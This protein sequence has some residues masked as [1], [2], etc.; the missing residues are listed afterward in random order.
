MAFGA[1]DFEIVVTVGDR[2][3]NAHFRVQLFPQLI[4]ISHLQARALLHVAAVRLHLFEQQLQQRRLTGSVRTDQADFIAALNQCG[5]VFD[6]G[7][8]A[9]AFAKSSGFDDLFA[10]GVAALQR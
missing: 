1:G 9:E 7:F 3:G 10:R 4:E 8:A 5:K 6:H 2:I